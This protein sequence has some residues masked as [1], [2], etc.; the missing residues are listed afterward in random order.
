MV[1]NNDF[2]YDLPFGI[3]NVALGWPDNNALPIYYLTDEPLDPTEI[4]A[5]SYRIKVLSSIKG[6]ICDSPVYT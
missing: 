6:T 3:I 1:Y 4:N 2:H 5:R